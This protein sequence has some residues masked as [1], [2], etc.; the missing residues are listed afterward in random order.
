VGT[1]YFLRRIDGGAIKIG[2]TSRRARD[3]QSAAQTFHDAD[4]LVLA[5][6]AGDAAL[7][8]CLHACF[9]HARR[10]GEWFEPV[11]ELLELVDAVNDGVSL[12]DYVAGL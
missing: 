2:Y 10:Q 3:R 11:Q 8:A 1:I 5:E 4:V 12:R 9:A 6:G 7:E